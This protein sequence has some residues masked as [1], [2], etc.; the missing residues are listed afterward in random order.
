MDLVCCFRQFLYP[1]EEETYR[2][3]RFLVERISESSEIRRDGND[4]TFGCGKEDG[5]KSYLEDYEEKEDEVETGDSFQRIGTKLN[6]FRL[7]SELSGSANDTNEGV[8]K[9]EAARDKEFS[10]QKDD[11]IL[12]VSEKIVNSIKDQPSKVCFTC[13]IEAYIV[14]L[15]GINSIC[16]FCTSVDKFLQLTFVL[17]TRHIRVRLRNWSVLKKR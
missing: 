10:A 9:V 3:I 4:K 13:R 14:C 5:F 16:S 8:L 12:L 7:T 6:D 1:S 11:G 2:L 17:F 15:K